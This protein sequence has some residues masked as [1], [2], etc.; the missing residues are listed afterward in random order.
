MKYLKQFGILI[1]V[2]F[3]GE[4]LKF[5]IPLPI[6]GS[7]YGLLLLL[8]LLITGLLKVEQIRE[9]A[10]F[11]IETMQVMFIPAA[12]GL[13]VSWSS[14]SDKLLPIGAITVVSTFVVMAVTGRTAESMLKGSWTGTAESMLKGSGNEAA[15]HMPEGRGI[16]IVESGL[17]RI[18]KEAVGST[19]TGSE[20]IRET[21]GRAEERGV[22]E[23]AE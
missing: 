23:N 14:L 8:L 5:F 7:I 3:M 20:K 19:G 11:L 15:E 17:K 21:A 22:K 10:E 18:G 12:V 1:A 9:A 2:T 4:I 16:D 13:M 6:P